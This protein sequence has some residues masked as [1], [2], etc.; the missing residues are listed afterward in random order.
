MDSLNILLIIN[1][2]SL[3]TFMANFGDFPV[4]IKLFQCK[5]LGFFFFKSKRVWIASGITEALN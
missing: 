4:N 2:K 5:K 3:F 1:I